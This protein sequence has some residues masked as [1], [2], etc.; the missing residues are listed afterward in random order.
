MLKIK[1][2]TFILWIKVRLRMNS[3]VLFSF[4]VSYFHKVYLIFRKNNQEMFDKFR[5]KI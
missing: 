3:E 2:K 4:E 1:R 5:Y